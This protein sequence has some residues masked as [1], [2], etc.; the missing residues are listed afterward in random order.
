MT[1]AYLL[2]N[3]QRRSAGWLAGLLF[4]VAAL[5]PLRA[6]PAPQWNDQL[7]GIYLPSRGTINALVIFAQ[8]PDDSLDID[9]PEW[10]VDQPPARLHTW[11]DSVWSTSPTP[12]SM[13]DYFDQMSL[14]AFRFIGKARFVTAPRTRQEYVALGKNR[15]DI[16]RELLARLDETMDFAEFDRWDPEG[17]FNHIERPD[18]IVDMVLVIWRNILD[19]IPDSETQDSVRSKLDFTWDIEDLGYGPALAVDGG[20]RR[21][22]MDYGM[23]GTTPKGSGLTLRKPPTRNEFLSVMK[24]SIHEVAHYLV[25]WNEYHCGFGFWGMLSSY[26][27][28]SYTANAFERHRLGWINLITLTPS[29]SLT[30]SNVALP[31]FVTTGTAVRFVIDSASGQYFYLENHHRLSRWDTPSRDTSERGLYVI[32]QDNKVDTSDPIGKGFHMRMIPADGRYN[33]AAP[34]R[35]THS[36]CGSIV[37]PVFKRLGPNRHTGYHDC[38]PIPYVSEAE[39]VAGVSDVILIEDSH[40]NTVLDVLSAGTGDDSFRPTTQTVF[41]PWSNPSS[42]DKHRNP[43]GYGFEVTGVRPTQAGDVYLLNLHARTA[44]DASPALLQGLALAREDNHPHLTWQPNEEPDLAAY[45]IYRARAASEQRPEDEEFELAATIPAVD[46]SGRPDTSWTDQAVTLTGGD[47][48][49]YYRIS[50][51][52]ISGKESQKVTGWIGYD[53]TS[54][55]EHIGGSRLSQPFALYPNPAAERVTLDFSLEA[56]SMVT[57]TLT[58]LPGDVALL[59]LRSSFGAGRHTVDI[60]LSTLAAGV[61]YLT[62]QTGT[63]SSTSLLMHTGW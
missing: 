55:V 13:T 7:G 20:A 1:T 9:H 16:H 47:L 6:Q 2:S 50:A 52:D 28:R 5:L 53:I 59:P 14:G 41:S 40:G 39:G 44:A 36:C 46:D 51:V 29:D 62:V 49:R 17:E 19:D 11:V 15:G 24:T 12:F 48:R 25:G 26:G 21:I 33:W 42:Q 32:R 60:D 35:E 27:I 63:F 18:G 45:R 31:D 58:S 57:V 10:P 54:G 4:A 61:Y 37:I 23:D 30:L 56:A 34:R 8:F 38:E 3:R 22:H 43:T